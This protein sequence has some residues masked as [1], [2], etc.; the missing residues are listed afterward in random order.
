V[1]VFGIRIK[2]CHFVKVGK[3]QQR[4]KTPHRILTKRLYLNLKLGFRF[5]KIIRFAKAYISVAKM[6]MKSCPETLTF[7][8]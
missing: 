5:P 3:T 2:S 7:A 6:D 4:Y 8:H 1:G